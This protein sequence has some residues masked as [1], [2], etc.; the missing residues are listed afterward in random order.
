MNNIDKH[1]L[2]IA[3]GCK[4][5]HSSISPLTRETFGKWQAGDYSGRPVIRAAGGVGF[6]VPRDVGN[7]P[8]KTGNRLLTVRES[9]IQQEMHFTFDVALNEPGV[10]K[11]EPVVPTLRSFADTVKNLIA[12]FAPLL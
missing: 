8:L 7:F 5:T 1:R 4:G 10:I 11:G 12:G 6:L 9:E 2:L 3:A